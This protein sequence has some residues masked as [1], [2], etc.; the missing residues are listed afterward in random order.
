MKCPE[1]KQQSVIYNVSYL[2]CKIQPFLKEYSVTI[3]TSS[4]EMQPGGVKHRACGRHTPNHRNIQIA[5]PS[6]NY[7]VFSKYLL[8]FQVRFPS[9]HPERHGARRHN[10]SWCYCP[11]AHGHDAWD[12]TVLEARYKTS[13][14]PTLPVIKQCGRPQWSGRGPPESPVP[15]LETS[16]LFSS[17]SWHLFLTRRQPYCHPVT[18]NGHICPENLLFV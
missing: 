16:L 9:M 18:L 15:S 17:T 12:S 7:I 11:D 2:C 3:Q 8:K 14:V 6:I 5:Y 1:G 4:M 13:Q 10:A